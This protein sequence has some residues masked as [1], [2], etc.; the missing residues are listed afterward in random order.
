VEL[1]ISLTIIMIISAVALPSF[2]GAYRNYQL[3][4]AASQ[5]AGIVKLTRLEAVRR[6]TLVTCQLQSIN[7]HWTLW[8]DSNGNG[9]LDSTEAQ[10]VGA[11]AADLLPASSVPDPGNFGF[12]SMTVLSG[13]TGSVTFDARGAVNFGAGTTVYAFYIGNAAQAGYGYRAVILLPSGLTQTWAATAQG[14]WH[15]IR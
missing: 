12:A 1:L 6:N 10:F 14:N 7:S 8:N 15:Q 2:A 3:S 11:G 9:L 4:S 5:L 13:G